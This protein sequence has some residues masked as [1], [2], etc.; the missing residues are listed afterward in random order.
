M[1]ELILMIFKTHK[2]EWLTPQRIREI[3][4]AIKGTNTPL[5]PVQRTINRLTKCD[6]LLRITNGTD[7]KFTLNDSLSGFYL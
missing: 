7:P 5:A 4:N 2:G 3:V 6:K 1:D